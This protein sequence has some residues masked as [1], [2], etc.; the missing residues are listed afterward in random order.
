[1]WL[2]G[3]RERW[4]TAVLFG[5]LGEEA[6]QQISTKF[7]NGFYTQTTGAMILGYIQTVCHFGPEY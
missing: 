2:I 4:D 1:L 5:Y 3:E 7:Y 6:I